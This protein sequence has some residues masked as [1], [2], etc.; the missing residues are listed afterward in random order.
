M[1]LE[2]N[3][4]RNYGAFISQQ[5]RQIEVW[6][7]ENQI[8][9][10]NSRVLILGAETLGQM[11]LGCCCGLGIG[12]ILMLDNT[13][14]SQSNFDFMSPSLNRFE[15][16]K[17]METLESKARQINDNINIRV[18]HSKFSRSILNYLE[19]KPDAILDAQN[20]PQHKEEALG[21][22]LDTGT[23][24]ISAYN[25]PTKAIISRLNPKTE[26]LSIIDHD[27]IIYEEPFQGSITSGLCAGIMVDELRK[28]IFQMDESDLPLE[29]RVE[30]NLKSANRTNLTLDL[31]LDIHRKNNTRV[32]VAG[33]GAIGNYV[34]LNLALSGFKKIDIIDF[35]KVVYHNLA[36]QILLHSRIGENKAKVL[37][38]RIGEINRIKS[39]VYER[40]LDAS[41]KDVIRRNKYDVIFG[42]FDNEMARYDLSEIA[43]ALK[44]PY[45][46]GGTSPTTG[47]LSVYYPNKTACIKCKKS[48]KPIE[49][50][51]SCQDAP[52][53]SVI[54]PNI[55]IG[56]LM[57][58]EAEHILNQKYIRGRI[59][60]DSG[61]KKRI[62]LASDG[63]S[64]SA[65]SCGVKNEI[66]N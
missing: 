6:G 26:P 19:F 42:C 17:V 49:V 22:A 62:Y 18:L 37:S 34:A 5:R 40:K 47:T 4:E 66:W 9:L 36:R 8:K 3:P 65:C 31:S 39:V 57:V 7:E 20:N 24:Y 35:D 52:N 55:I 46:D 53:P 28:S 51:E 64:N 59:I 54:I 13:R 23:K 12:D 27:G 21:F 2:N 33:A 60:F 44:I 43:L 15:N 50:K 25:S 29:E 10:L 41:F 32:L 16:A 30:Y 48:L 61:Y 14:S 1:K 63:T 11:V 38:D 45:I 58:G 56:S